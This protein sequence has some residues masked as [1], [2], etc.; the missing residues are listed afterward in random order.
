MYANA[1]ACR[2]YE[3]YHLRPFTTMYGEHLVIDYYVME[4]TFS[5]LSIRTVSLTTTLLAEAASFVTRRSLPCSFPPP[6]G[7]VERVQ[8]RHLIYPPSLARECLRPL[9]RSNN[10]G[11][12]STGCRCPMISS[13]TPS[14]VRY[15]MCEDLA[16]TMSNRFRLCG[17]EGSECCQTCLMPMLAIPT[18]SYNCDRLATILLAST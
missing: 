5:F 11:L 15:S 3:N 6:P 12:S 7:L 14:A 16:N 4:L 9:T 1:E 8:K 17:K 13:S 2:A 10:N 18:R